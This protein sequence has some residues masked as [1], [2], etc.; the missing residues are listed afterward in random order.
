MY[1]YIYIY[2][3]RMH[4]MNEAMSKHYNNY[5]SYT[6]VLHEHVYYTEQTLDMMIMHAMTLL[7]APGIAI[8]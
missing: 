2:I 3:V 8:P 5:Y 4:A 6:F 7:Q 1:I